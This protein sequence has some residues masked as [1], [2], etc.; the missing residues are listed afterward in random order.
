MKLRGKK[1][2]LGVTGSIAAYKT[3]SLVRLLKKQGAV[4]KVIATP[5]A[6]HFITP[7]TLATLSENPVLSDF[8][9]KENN[10]GLWNN[11]VEFGLWADVFL[12]APATANTLSKMAS[13]QADNL[14]LATYLSARCPVYFAPAMDVDMY[15]HLATQNN[16]KILQNRGDH[17]IPSRY[18]QLAS[19]LEG[20]GRMEE[21]EEIL[22]ILLCGMQSNLPLLGK[23]VMIT[24]GPTYEKIDPVRFIGNH[25]S[26]KMGFAMARVAANLGATVVL[27]TGTTAEKINDPRVHRI[28]VV[29]TAEMY[30]AVHHYFQESIIA[31]FSAAVADY[32]L[33]KPSP[34]KIKKQADD[35]SL[36][37]VKTVDILASV[38]PLKKANQFVVGFALETE[39]ELQAAIEKAQRKGTDLM[40]LNSLND[41]GAGFGGDTNKVTLIDEKAAEDLPLM[42]KQKLAMEILERV[43]KMQN[44]D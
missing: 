20:E 27:I 39:N 3:A 25:S 17:L 18:G 33:A 16:I 28:D 14:L 34:Q 1:I 43:L 38:K 22:E 36:S 41:M 42:S 11:H 9:E 5:D 26:G 40:V 30:E 15:R 13:G 2:L 8:Y 35:L 6:F 44:V 31:I 10:K 32:T 29:T 4:V 19:G 21:P 23:K 24:A 37:L 12:I 7:L